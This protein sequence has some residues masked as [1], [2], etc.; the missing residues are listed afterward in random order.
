M[1]ASEPIT[2]PPL[3][4]AFESVNL[5][6]TRPQDE[7][8]AMVPGDFAL[9]HQI[10]PLMVDNGTLVAAVGSPLSL[11]AV[12][13]LSVLL[14]RPTRAV[15]APAAVIKEKI[16][17]IFLEKILAGLPGQSD[18]NNNI[19]A[20]ENTDLADL[21]KMAGETAV[22]QMVNLVFAQAVRDGAS[23]IHIEPYEKEVK[24]RCRIDGMLRDMMAPP[25]RMHA[26]II[27]RLKILGEMNIAERRL[28]QDG[29]IKIT[30]AGRAIDVRVS[31]VPT[32]FGERA[33]MRILDKGTAML[34]LAELGIQPDTLERY[35]Q[36]I[37]V[38]YG[39]ILATGPTGAGKST[40]LYASLQEI[41][42]PTTN[43]LT[44]EDPV[45]YQVAGISQIPVRAAIGLTFANGLR[46][47]VRQDPDVIMVGEIRDHETA[48]I[49]IHAA[50]TGH[51]VFS[52]LHTND[53]PGSVTRL[54]DMGV[55]PYLVASSLIGAVAQRLV[56]RVCSNCSQPY[57]PEGE[58]LEGVGIVASEWAGTTPFRKGVGCEKCQG[59]G[60]KGRVGL[61]EL[62]V[63]DEPIRRMTV[64]RASSNQMKDYAIKT[65]GMRTLLGDGK[66]AVL[67][68]KTTP[69]EVLRVCQ[70][71][72]F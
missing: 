70:R 54:L 7:A 11:G 22:V 58:M 52:T 5:E 19:D 4:D 49:A 40:T 55:E 9:K 60:Y 67:A 66:L 28:P 42:S 8:V 27:S 20:D 53:S 71:E 30:I 39:V 62:F 1:T 36:I 50:L 68:G 41:W 61:Y 69:E 23:D 38:P 15:L 43:I 72:A 44:I 51:L 24:V 26:A 35:R 6:L 12:D 25:K 65:H 46:S 45:E 56:R 34:G 14:Q 31:I 37:K 64:D 21:Q 63:V 48:E 18:D 33:V 13:E 17:E 47:I 10:L 32:V 16:E 59:T 2:L 3:E 57:T 29:R